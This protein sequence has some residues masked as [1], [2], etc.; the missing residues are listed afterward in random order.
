MTPIDRAANRL[1]LLDE[2][3]AGWEGLA[4][5]ERHAY[6]AQVLEVLRALREP[7]EP[8]KEAGALIVRNVGRDEAP[9]AYEGDAANVWRFMIDALMGERASRA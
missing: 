8:M 7:D 3:G 4:E 5:S 6:R 1:A 9:E 2:D